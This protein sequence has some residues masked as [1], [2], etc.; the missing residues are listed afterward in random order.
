MESKNLVLSEWGGA[1]S[2]KRDAMREVMRGLITDA[3]L[4]YSFSEHAA[5]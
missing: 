4:A 2:S 3:R 5:Y 1:D